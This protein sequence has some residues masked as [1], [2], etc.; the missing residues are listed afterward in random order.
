MKNTPRTHRR[1]R[2][3]TL[4]ELLVVIGIIALLISILLPALNS[5]RR[6]AAQAKCGAQMR[7]LANAAKMYAIDNRG[8]YPPMRLGE[9]G[10]KGSGAYE[11]SGVTYNAAASTADGLNYDNAAWWWNFLARYVT[12][13]NTSAAA[14]RGAQADVQASVLWGCPS[15]D[16]YL[17]PAGNAQGLEFR[18][19]YTGY[20]WNPHPSFRAD[21]PAAGV[22][23]PPETDVNHGSFTKGNA[24]LGVASNNKWS[25]Y[26]GIWYKETAYTR[27][28]QRAL[29]ADCYYVA[30]EA[31]A[32]VSATDLP[33]MKNYAD[34]TEEFSK[35][36]SGQQTT[37]QTTFDWYRHGKVPPMHD[38]SSTGAFKVSG[39]KIAYNILYADGHVGQANDKEESYRS[40]RMRFPEPQ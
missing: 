27:P 40:L 4:V 23:R 33:G 39:G 36:V 3:F 8:Y 7:N 21:Y 11:I 10:A 1:N 9:T 19:N 15:F 17:A 25:S 32:P 24:A 14:G 26:I 37:G 34:P 6:S 29:F 35:N 5:A 16:K 22:R 2:G 18:Q 12:K 31:N 38:P 13:A 30:L 20:A 28:A